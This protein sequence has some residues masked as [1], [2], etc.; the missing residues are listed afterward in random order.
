MRSSTLTCLICTTGF[1]PQK[2][3]RNVARPPGVRM[4]RRV[5]LRLDSCQRRCGRFFAIW[6]SSQAF[7]AAAARSLSG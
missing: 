2:P 1:K 6:V 5:L 7:A 3:A 4:E